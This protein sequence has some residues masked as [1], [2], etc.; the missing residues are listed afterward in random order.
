MWRHEGEKER[1]DVNRVPSMLSDMVAFG[2][3]N[4]RN[5]IITCGVVVS[6][7]RCTDVLVTIIYLWCAVC[8]DPP[9][10]SARSTI[11]LCS[12]LCQSHLQFV[13]VFDI[14]AGIESNTRRQTKRKRIVSTTKKKKMKKKMNI[15]IMHIQCGASSV[16]YFPI[17]WANIEN[18]RIVRKPHTQCLCP[19]ESN[20]VTGYVQSN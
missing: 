18:N 19:F 20:T 14:Y 10:N 15:I 4:E 1:A 2:N 11:R 17:V 8:F 3:N 5:F 13:L 16:Q 9:N 7:T 6:S 12:I